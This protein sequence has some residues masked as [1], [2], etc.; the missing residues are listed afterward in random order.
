MSAEVIHQDQPL[1]TAGAPLE[2]ARAAAILLHGR[3]AGAHDLLGLA[4]ALPDQGVAYLLPQAA[5]HTWY[6]HS[7]FAPLAANEP[8]LS[9]AMD[10]IRKL[11]EQVNAAGI[12]T[13]KV[14]LGGFSQ[15][16]CLSA[17]FAARHARRY[18]ALLVLTGALMGP[19]DMPRAYDGTLDGTPVFIGG[20][21]RDPWVTE[22]QMRHTAGTLEQLGG[23]VT[24]QIEPGFQHT[25][26]PSEIDRAS[27]IIRQLA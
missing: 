21:D 17:E 13:E 20:I 15:G 18:G 4:A 25:I 12:P 11:I 22:E 9:S 24:I 27:A 16:A 1:L 10:T 14:V 5:N 3:G 23:Q 6:P 26:R 2:E 8:Y 7:G 19:L